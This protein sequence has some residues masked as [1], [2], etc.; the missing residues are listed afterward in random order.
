MTMCNS[1]GALSQLAIG[2]QAMEFLS[3]RKGTRTELVDNG[4]LAIRG[5]FTHAKE[6]VTLGLV[7]VEHVITMQPSPSELDVLLPLMGFAESPTDTF[8]EEDDLDTFTMLIDRVAK[9]HTYENSIIDKWVFRGQ[10]G[11][12]PISL[13]LTILS[14]TES[15][16]NAG[17]FSATAIDTSFAYAFTEGVLTVQGGAEAFDRFALACDHKAKVEHNNSRT[18]TCIAPTDREISLACST[19][20]TSSETALYTTPFG[21]ASGAGGTLVFTRSTRSTTF[22]FANLKSIATVPEIP[23]KEEIRLPLFYRAYS[24]G[25]TKA[26]V[27]T[28]DNTA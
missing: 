25:S 19:P 5:T 14:P 15:E 13:E 3:I 28:H 17:T 16:G 18:A 1:Q 4:D 7:W 2:G 21:D 22:T 26:L 6:R 24:S 9:V 11:R 27:I 20:Y 23:G 12:L 8:T 10:K